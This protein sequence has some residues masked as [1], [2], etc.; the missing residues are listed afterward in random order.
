ME[1]ELT[2][3]LN[4]AME[5]IKEE[6]GLE[7]TDDELKESKKMLK[8]AAKEQIVAMAIIKQVVKKRFG[9]LQT[10]LKNSYVKKR[11]S[12]PPLWLML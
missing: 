5:K 1:E 10:E 9:D 8:A 4:E 6:T 2:E 12:F 11:T 3:A 7:A